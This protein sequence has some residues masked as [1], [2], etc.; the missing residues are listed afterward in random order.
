MVAARTAAA[1]YRMVVNITNKEGKRTLHYLDVN[2]FNK[3]EAKAG[4]GNFVFDEYD[5]L[6]TLG[7]L[8]S[9]S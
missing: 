7:T 9:D 4:H 8:L 5:P 3:G 2:K 1:D 6:H